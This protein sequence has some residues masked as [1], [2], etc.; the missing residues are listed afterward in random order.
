MRKTRTQPDSLEAEYDDWY[1]NNPKKWTEPNRNEFLV[2]ALEGY[3]SPK[4]IIDIGCGNG[5]TLERLSSAFPDAELYGLDLSGEALKLVKERLPNATT[6]HS[7]LKGYTGN[8]FDLVVCMGTG[9]HF[10]DLDKNLVLLKRLTHRICY[11]EVPNNLSYDPGEET[12]RR[13]SKGSQ[14][15]EWHLPKKAWEAKLLKAGFRIL[16][17][18]TGQK[19]TWEFIWILG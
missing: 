7:T 2:S 17:G 11:F 4:N 12:Y 13:L 16:E 9:E 10:E 3:S 5:H 14:Q 8:R 15:W 19:V 6:I 1:R 18:F